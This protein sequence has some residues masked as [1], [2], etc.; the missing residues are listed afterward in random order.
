MNR[1]LKEARRINRALSKNRPNTT[2]SSLL[3]EIDAAL[4]LAKGF[5]FANTIR[6]LWGAFNL[7]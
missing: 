3:H 6:G 2:N 5:L 1:K 4:I 7:N